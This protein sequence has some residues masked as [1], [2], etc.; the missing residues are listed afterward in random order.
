MQCEVQISLIRQNTES[1]FLLVSID[2]IAEKTYKSLKGSFCT[3]LM[4]GYEKDFEQ[5]VCL[6]PKLQRVPSNATM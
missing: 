3:M 2:I 5:M 1:M 6:Q 4:I